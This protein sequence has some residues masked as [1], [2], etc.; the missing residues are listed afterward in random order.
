MENPLGG[1]EPEAYTLKQ[2][3]DLL[4][5]TTRTVRNWIKQGKIQAFKLGSTWR[6]RREEVDRLLNRPIRDR[7]RG[8]PDTPFGDNNTQWNG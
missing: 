1:S 6:I 5:V 3:A 7:R 2:A 4:Q 8:V